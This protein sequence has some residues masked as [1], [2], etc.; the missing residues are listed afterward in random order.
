MSNFSI[1]NRRV[2]GKEEGEKFA[3]ENN[4]IF[5]ETS[6]L[7]SDNVEKVFILLNVLK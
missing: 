3:K 6:A 7:T 1:N 2:V 4:L 5:I